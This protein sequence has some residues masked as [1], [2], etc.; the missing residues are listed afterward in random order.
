M[1]IMKILKLSTIVILISVFLHNCS[2]KIDPVTGEKVII[3]PNP[4]KK[5]REYADKGGGIFGDI[6][7]IGKGSSNSAAVD[8]ATSNV[9]WKATLKTLD[10]LPLSNAN[11]SGGIIVYDW[12]SE[13]LSDEQIKITIK[14]LSNDIKSDSIEVIAHKKKCDISNKCSVQLAGDNLSRNIK[15]KIITAARLL[16]I[17][18][19]KNK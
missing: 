10:F 2:S 13:N 19:T 14:F 1:F 3:E 9:L 16:K 5:A 8:F 7:K 18:E 6:N 11:Y 12:Y 4:D 17:E 15:D